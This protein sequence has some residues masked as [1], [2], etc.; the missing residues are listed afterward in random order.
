VL[1]QGIERHL[2]APLHTLFNGDFDIKQAAFSDM[3]NNE[4]NRALETE[5]QELEEKIERLRGFYAKLM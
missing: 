1:V 4:D 3:L 2:L 5:K